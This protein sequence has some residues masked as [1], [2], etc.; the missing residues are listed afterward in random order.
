M[1]EKNLMELTDNMPNI[2]QEGLAKGSKWVTYRSDD[3]P[4]TIL[5][6]FPNGRL[7]SVTLNITTEEIIVLK[8]LKETHE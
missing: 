8:V 1:T 6:E 3:Y 4:N 2:A 5:R 7:E